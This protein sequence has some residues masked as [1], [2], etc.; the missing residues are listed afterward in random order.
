MKKLYLFLLI[1]LTS[2]ARMGTPDGGWFDDTPPRV[3]GSSPSD[4]GTDVTSRRITINFNEYIK[5]EDAQNKV[6]VSP[7][8]LEMPEIKATGKRIVIDLQDSLKANT[9]YTIDFSD[10]ISDNNEGNP[11]GNYAFTF[12]TGKQIDT[13]QVSGYVLNAENLE[14]IKGMLVGLYLDSTCVDTTFHKLPMM[15]VSRTN[16]SGRFTIKGVAPGNYRVFALKDADGD[17]VY[18]QKSEDI[19]FSHEVVTPSSKLDT[20][21]DTIWM[22]SLRISRI[23]RVEYT[24]FLPDEVTLLSFQVPQTDRYLVKTERKEPEKLGFFFSYGSDSLPRLRGLNFEADNAFFVEPST[25]LDTIYYWLRDTALVNQDT[26]RMEATYMMTD[27]TGLLVEKVDTIEALAKIP[28]AKRLKEKQKEF[29]K[30]QKEQE[31]K[32]KRNEPYDSIMPIEFLRPKLST[33]GQLN[34]NQNVFIEMPVPLDSCHAEGVHLYSMIDSLW[35]N[36]PLLFEQINPRLYV[37]KA[38][39]R[40]DIEYSLEIDSA[41][42]QTIFGEVNK[43]IKQGIKVRSEDEFS[44]LMVNITNMPDSGNVIIQMMDNGDKVVRETTVQDGTAEFYYVTPKKYYLR[45]IIDWN[46]NGIWDTGDYDAD[47]QPEPVYYFHEEIECKAKWDVTRNWALNSR[48]LFRQKP[49][50]I[51][52]QKPDQEKQLRD[53][54]AQRAASKGIPYVPKD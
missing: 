16:G 54:N 30:W 13:L 15:R 28:Y 36:A 35:Y 18:G 12:S 23:N 38:E 20:R 44:T 32:K 1:C 31:K 53:R 45:A 19:A 5:I 4:R 34:P 6:I 24:H 48:P 9:T 11:M 33:N 37:V 10:A 43:P 22:D 47:R 39:W 25:K 14:P 8:Q 42:F 3:V 49:V 7:P 27:S 21:Q 51:T 40:P 50:A 26:L 17:F 41:S 46:K 52:K 29:E 2:C